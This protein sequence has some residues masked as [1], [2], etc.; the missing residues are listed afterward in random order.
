MQPIEDQFDRQK[1]KKYNLMENSLFDFQQ[2]GIEANKNKHSFGR[3]M[4]KRLILTL[5]YL[6]YFGSGLLFFKD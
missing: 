6:R 4:F 3:G 5:V 2:S 1:V